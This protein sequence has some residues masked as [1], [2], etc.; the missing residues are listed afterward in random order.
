MHCPHALDK[1]VIHEIWNSFPNELKS[2]SGSKFRSR[3]DIS[4]LSF[5]YHAYSFVNGY[6]IKEDSS[7]Y[8]SYILNSANIDH[9]KTLESI[10]QE[11][12]S[13][14]FVCLNDGGDGRFTDRILKALSVKF[15]TKA[16]WEY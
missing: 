6:S 9:M 8:K 15:P 7:L 4:P 16:E 11:N 5:L 14:D 2:V 13:V 10:A 1:D 3:E 12:M